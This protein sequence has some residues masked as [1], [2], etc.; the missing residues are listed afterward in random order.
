MC[1][2]CRV[3][4]AKNHNFWQILTFGGVAPV[5]TPFY[6]WGPKQSANAAGKNCIAQL[7]QYQTRSS[8]V[9]Q[10][11]FDATWWKMQLLQV[12]ESLSQ[13]H[14]EDVHTTR[15]QN[16]VLLS[17]AAADDQSPTY[18]AEQTY[19]HAMTKVYLITEFSYGS[20][21]TYSVCIIS[22]HNSRSY[23]TYSI[24][25]PSNAWTREKRSK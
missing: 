23:C 8:A 19:S 24:W 25:V 6:R 2:L 5:P 17:Q 20:K 4:V 15:H 22:G 13:N 11:P 16:Q 7:A 12:F 18:E 3:P 10:T 21:F 14:F 9:T 1:S